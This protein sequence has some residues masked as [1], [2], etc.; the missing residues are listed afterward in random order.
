MAVL[1][2]ASGGGGEF[3]PAQGLRQP[4]SQLHPCR[5]SLV[6][7]GVNELFK[8]ALPLGL[9]FPR[10]CHAELDLIKMRTHAANRLRPPAR[11][12]ATSR[13]TPAS[14]TRRKSRCRFP[15][16]CSATSCSSSG[17]GGVDLSIAHVP[18]GTVLLYG[19]STTSGCRV[20]ASIFGIRWSDRS[21]V[22]CRCRR[23]T[24]GHGVYRFGV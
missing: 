16:P 8:L 21:G 3:L 23:S 12:L 5:P 15:A 13:S 18:I 4:V 2:P 19:G 9:D 6:K 24:G 14:S 20:R 7:D 1:R 11:A 17:I 10:V 22:R